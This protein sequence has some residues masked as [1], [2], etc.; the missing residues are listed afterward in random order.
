MSWAEVLGITM[1]NVIMKC[2]SRWDVAFYA[3]DYDW[4]GESAG[5]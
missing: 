1:G 5:K 2:I 4:L 3:L